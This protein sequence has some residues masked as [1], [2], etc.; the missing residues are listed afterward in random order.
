[1]NMEEAHGFLNDA[2]GHIFDT[3]KGHYGGNDDG[4]QLIDF[5][6]SSG[7][8]VPFCRSSALKY[9][10]RY[11]K[12]QGFNKIDLYKAIHFICLLYFFSKDE[13]TCL[14]KKD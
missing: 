9:V 8:G 12:K 2:L 10:A 1:M 5:I 11:G 3:F 6:H 4:I 14:P 13:E 7:D